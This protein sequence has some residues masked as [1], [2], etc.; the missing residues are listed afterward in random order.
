LRSA[1]QT[2][3]LFDAGTS[4]QPADTQ[5]RNLPTDLLMR[6]A[7]YTIPSAA[8]GGNQTP[9]TQEAFLLEIVVALH[10]LHARY[11]LCGAAIL[12]TSYS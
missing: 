1:Y 8:Y 11:I 9:L 5:R 10:E 7:K 2:R 12:L 6:P 4:P 3:S